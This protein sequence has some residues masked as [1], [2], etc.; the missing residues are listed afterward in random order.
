MQDKFLMLREKPYQVQNRLLRISFTQKQN[1]MRYLFILLLLHLS[2]LSAQN[3]ESLFQKLDSAVANRSYFIEKKKNQL[4]LLKQM[5][6]KAQ[7]PNEKYSLGNEIFKEYSKVNR[8]S[9]IFYVQ[10]NY[11]LAKQMAEPDKIANSEMNYIFM[12]AASGMYKECF[13]FLPRLNPENYPAEIKYQ[14]YKLYEYIYQGL[15]IYSAD[16][17]RHYYTTAIDSIYNQIL[18]NLEPSSPEYQETQARKAYNNQDFKNT[19][20]FTRECLKHIS[21]GTNEYAMIL[22]MQ[23]NAYKKL[24][25]EENYLKY[26]TEVAEIDIRSA[27]REYR[28]LTELAEYLYQ[29]GDIERAYIYSRR[30]LEDAEAFKARQHTLEIARIL[31]IINDAYQLRI[32]EEKTMFKYLSL[33]LGCCLFLLAL[34]I[35]FIVHQM[36]QLKAAN[37]EKEKMI[38]QL[39]EINRIKEEYIGHFMKLCSE[40]LVKLNDFRKLVNRKLKSGQYEDLYKFSSSKKTIEKEQIELFRKFDTSFLQLYPNFLSEINSLLKEEFRFELK[41]DELLNTEL[42]IC[43]LIK[44]GVKD[45]AQIS[46]FLGYSP[47]TIYTYRTKVRNRAI[48][49]DDFEKNITKIGH[50]SQ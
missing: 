18:A 15:Q 46:E 23:A 29:K 50:I 41:K 26:M 48:H 14:Y 35:W 37:L 44:L 40:Y 31:P 42:R 1:N 34:A 11:T 20:H 32:K 21:Y 19:I 28:A 27:V 10:E 25:D 33:V 7:N 17:Y 6:H 16:S 47:N 30:S 2:Q 4:N 3:Q 43:A 22:Y 5:Y 8:D 12:M 49:R 24:G 38:L 9:A 39:S 36:K 45:S 13:D